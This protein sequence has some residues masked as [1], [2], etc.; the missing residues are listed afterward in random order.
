MFIF[1]FFN[2]LIIKWKFFE[3]VYYICMRFNFFSEL[4][5]LYI[6]KMLNL[7]SITNESK[8]HNQK[9]PYIPDYRY[10][11]LISGGSGSG[12]TNP[13]LNLIEEQD[14]I[15]KIYLYGKDLCEPK[16][17]F[18]IKKRKNV[19]IKHLNDSMGLL[20]VQILWMTFMRILISTTQM[21]K[22][23]DDMIADIMTN[24]NISSHN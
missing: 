2:V 10:R 20:S 15:D 1:W 11:V 22:L 3:I 18:L 13:L 9:W 7:D 8:E 5:L 4:S 6:P 17:K 24:L 23:F 14:D 16:H 21:E 12:K 19:G